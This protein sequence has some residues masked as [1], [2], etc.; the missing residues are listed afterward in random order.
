ME[1][2]NLFNE[3]CGASA[4]YPSHPD[5]KIPKSWLIEKITDEKILGELLRAIDSYSGII[6]RNAL[7]FTS[8]IPLRAENL[9]ELKWA[10]IDLDKAT[11]TIPRSKM[12]VKDKKLPDFILPL[13][14]QAIAILQEIK[15]L[16]GWG[17]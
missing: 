17:E 16:T 5:D 12:K 13:P 3:N 9:S 10:Y 8:I 7:R 1:S 4:P 15:E 11:L 2:E 14:R 6:I